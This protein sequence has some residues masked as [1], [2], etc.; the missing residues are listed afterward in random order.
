MPKLMKM[1][2]KM[3]KTE[4]SPEIRTQ[5]RQYLEQQGYGV[6]ERAKLLGKSGIE[7]TFDML[8]QRN[9]GFTSYN[10]A[11]GIATGDS[12]KEVGMIFSLANK[13]YDCGILDRILISIPEL[14]QETKELARKQRIKVIDGEQ[15]EQLLTVKPSKPVKTEER[16]SYETK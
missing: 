11:I 6:T 10:I 3:P 1:A 15:I 2:G 14:S 12:E 9:D 4:I 13:A 8:A 5:V 16:V 7:H